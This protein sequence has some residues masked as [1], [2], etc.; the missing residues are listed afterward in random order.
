MFVGNLPFDFGNILVDTF[1][2]ESGSDMVQ[3]HWMLKQF[4]SPVLGIERFFETGDF[5]NVTWGFQDALGSFPLV[6]T[7]GWSDAVHTARGDGRDGRQEAAAQRRHRRVQRL[8]L[9]APVV[10]VYERMLFENSFVNALYIGHDQWDRNPYVLP[11]RDPDGNIQRD[12]TGVARAQNLSTEQYIA[13]NKD[14]LT[15][16]RR[17]R[18]EGP[19]VVDPG[20]GDIQD[21]LRQ[22]RHLR[23]RA[24]RADREPRHHGA[25][26]EPVHRRAPVTATTGATTC[27]PRRRRS[28]SRRSTRR[29]RGDT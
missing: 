21:R 28:P 26:H 25:G 24:A 16:D 10:G 7:L 29:G 2:G 9:A 6:N 18:L 4:V 1:G 17:R 20:T 8:L 5:R 19:A 23:R 11:L 12:I 15:G 3:L 27:P 22:P 13:Q 14:Q